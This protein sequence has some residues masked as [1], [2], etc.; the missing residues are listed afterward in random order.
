MNVHIHILL[1]CTDSN[2]YTYTYIQIYT[3]AYNIHIY[4]Y[5]YI[6]K[7][8]YVHLYMYRYGYIRGGDGHT[9]TVDK[10]LLDQR[11]AP[12]VPPHPALRS[13]RLSVGWLNG[14]VQGPRPLFGD[15]VRPFRKRHDHLG[16]RPFGNFR[17]LQQGHLNN[18]DHLGN[19]MKCVKAKSMHALRYLAHEKIPPPKTLQEAYA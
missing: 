5:T 9:A 14:R 13:E 6:Y 1:I 4:L 18:S 11:A 16:N 19:G 17:P 15:R 3:Y 12:V 2:V 10:V 7:Y 8:K